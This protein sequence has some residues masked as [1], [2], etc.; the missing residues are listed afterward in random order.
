MIPRLLRL[1][2]WNRYPCSHHCSVVGD[3]V[4]LNLMA[5]GRWIDS[6]LM[7]SA[8]RVARYWVAAGPAQNAVTSSTRM[9]SNGR[10]AS[11]RGR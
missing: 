7:T 5:S 4:T 9:P 11:C 1:A 6:T 2:E 8:P 3:T 10:T